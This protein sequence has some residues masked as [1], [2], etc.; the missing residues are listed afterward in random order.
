MMTMTTRR[1]QLYRWSTTYKDYDDG[2]YD[3]EVD[4]DDDDDEAKTIVRMMTRYDSSDVD[5]D[6]ITQ[7]S[8]NDTSDDDIDDGDNDND[9]NNRG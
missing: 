7:V 9:G 1:S 2:D 5:D 3:D 4:D 6:S 8:C